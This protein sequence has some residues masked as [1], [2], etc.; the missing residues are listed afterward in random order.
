MCV[1]PSRIEF[2]EISAQEREFESELTS[3]LA[4]LPE[5]ERETKK[6]QMLK[7][8]ALRFAGIMAVAGAH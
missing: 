5:R 4:K 7:F 3:K 6:Q 8:S 2:E 1:L